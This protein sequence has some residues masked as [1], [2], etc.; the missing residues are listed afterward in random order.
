MLR[1]LYL[2]VCVTIDRSDQ[3]VIQHHLKPYLG[4]ASGQAIECE[5]VESWN[6]KQEND[7]IL[8]FSVLMFAM[9]LYFY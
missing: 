6:L 9:L 1:R 2:R 3:F 5:H 4:I 8:N 7:I